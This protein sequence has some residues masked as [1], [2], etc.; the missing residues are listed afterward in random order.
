MISVFSR[1]Y[2][3]KKTEEK[4]MDENYDL[5]PN[6][7]IQPISTSEAIRFKALKRLGG[8][9]MVERMNEYPTLDQWARYFLYRINSHDAI[10]NALNFY[11]NRV[12]RPLVDV[13]TENI[14]LKI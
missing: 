3:K 1:I 6:E 10:I 14:A 4:I 2:R 5:D 8:P 12:K 9:I 11:G 13:D 7:I